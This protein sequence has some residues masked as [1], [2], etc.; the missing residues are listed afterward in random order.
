MTFDFKNSIPERNN[1]L[2]DRYTQINKVKKKT[3]L[4]S[5]ESFKINKI[6]GLRLKDD[7]N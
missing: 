3:K 1:Q 4:I 6:L 2:S 7:F 5:Q